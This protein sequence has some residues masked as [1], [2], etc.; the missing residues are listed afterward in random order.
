[1]NSHDDYD[2][3]HV[4]Q[5]HPRPPAALMRNRMDDRPPL[6]G[7]DGPDA[8]DHD[9]DPDEEEARI[10][11]FLRDEGRDR[12][13]S[14]IAREHGLQSRVLGDE[15]RHERAQRYYGCPGG[16]E[17]VA[18]LKEH[19]VEAMVQQGILPRI[20]AE[21]RSKVFEMMSCRP[22]TAKDE[23]SEELVDG[24]K[25]LKESPHGLAVC[26]LVASFLEH[27]GMKET[28]NVFKHEA[29]L[30]ADCPISAQDD[31]RFPDDIVSRSYIVPSKDQLC[32]SLPLPP[33]LSRA[34]TDNPLLQDIVNYTLDRRNAVDDGLNEL[35]AGAAG[36]GARVDMRNGLNH[37]SEDA[38]QDS[39]IHFEVTPPGQ[40]P[41]TN[42]QLPSPLQH[43]YDNRPILSPVPPS[44]PLPERDIRLSGLAGAYAVGDSLELSASFDDTIAGKM[45]EIARAAAA[46]GGQGIEESTV[47]GSMAAR[48]VHDLPD[49]RHTRLPPLDMKKT[50]SLTQAEDAAG[51]SAGLD[52]EDDET[53]GQEGGTDHKAS[54][55]GDASI[56][57]DE[58]SA[59]GFRASEGLSD[60]VGSTTTATINTN[61]REQDATHDIVNY[62]LDRRNAVDDGLNEL[63]AGAAGEGAR[64]DMRNG[65]NHRSE[66][67]GQDSDIHFE[68][69]PPGQTPM[70]NSQLPSP[71][72]HSYDNRP[73]LSPV[74]PSK[75]L[76]ERDIRLSGLA[77][78]YAVGD[79]LELSASFDDTIAGKMREIARAAAAGGGQGIEESTVVGSM[80]ARDVHDLPDPRHTR[81][82]P[83]DMKKTQSLTQAEDAAGPSAGLDDEDDETGGQE[84][85]TDH[86]ASHDGDASIGADEMSADGF[87]ASEGL[88]DTVGSTTTATINTNTREQDA[89]H[90]AS[91]PTS[92]FGYHRRA[93]PPSLTT[94]SHDKKATQDL[95]L[96]GPVGGKTAGGPFATVTGAAAARASSLDDEIEE[97][98]EADGEYDDE[99][100]EPS[101]DGQIITRDDQPTDEGGRQA[102]FDPT[103]APPSH[104]Q[105]TQDNDQPTAAVR[106]TTTRRTDE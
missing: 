59:D 35:L 60:T 82:P 45:R 93:W 52:D 78:A 57:A 73:I 70:T 38:G 65:L 23:R 4:R 91:K 98:I 41:M 89:T 94:S 37:R 36:E 88:S 104:D 81:L 55:D 83:L 63:L 30:Y 106:K 79:S 47:V 53:G 97:E 2:F 87:R 18:L 22:P 29:M 39:D 80:A 21:L 15:E 54:H 103:A 46:G 48:D 33:S 56:G 24:I 44:K 49:P 77:G 66:D 31:G 42:S 75:P 9:E 96:D 68:V 12:R 62:T 11:R 69:T 20:K 19:V 16:R 8:C 43:S 61:T 90:G 6:N 86:K 58:M 71:L 101:D 74:P 64:V 105:H 102:D 100:F 25:R 67:A 28:L 5:L 84:G 40:T 72:Q 34:S 1:M 14:T 76:P 50:Q 26:N 10:E 27:Y 51:P 99:E 3:E 17:K 92:I 7:H 85:G 13:P 32:E 95:N